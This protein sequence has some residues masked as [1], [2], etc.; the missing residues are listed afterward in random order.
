VVRQKELYGE[1]E[2]DGGCGEEA[3]EAHRLL[4]SKGYQ[5]NSSS[6]C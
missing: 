5:Q 6:N 1:V 3:L 4:C 2:R